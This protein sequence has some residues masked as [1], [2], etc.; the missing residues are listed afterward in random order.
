LVKFIPKLE[1]ENTVK[2]RFCLLVFDS[3]NTFVSF[4][5]ALFF[6]RAL[7]VFKNTRF[8]TLDKVLQLD[9]KEWLDRYISIK[10]FLSFT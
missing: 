8:S 7:G 2:A 10:Y 9:L 4:N 5:L 6:F 1:L 3:K